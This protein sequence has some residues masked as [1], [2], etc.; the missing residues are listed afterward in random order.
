[1]NSFWDKYDN[2]IDDSKNLNKLEL[3]EKLSQVKRY[4]NGL[5]D[6]WHDFM[7]GLKD[8]LNSESLDKGDKSRIKEI[9]KLTEKRLKNR[10]LHNNVFNS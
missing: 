5:T 7:N 10:Q 9:I 2:L 1:M 4:V 3:A 8:I 6:G